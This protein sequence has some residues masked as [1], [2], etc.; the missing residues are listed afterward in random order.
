MLFFI[1]L[2]SLLYFQRDRMVN[3]FGTSDSKGKTGPAGP[4][5]PVGPGGLKEVIQWFPRMILQQIRQELNALTL[6]IENLPPNKDADVELSP[7]KTVN[8]WKL[9]NN[10]DWVLKPVNEGGVLKQVTLELDVLK[11]YGLVFNKSKGIMYHMEQHTMFLTVLSNVL[12]TLTF[13]VGIPDD[14]DDEDDDDVSDKEGEEE[15]IISDYRWTVFHKS[16]EK[17]RGVSIIPKPDEK[18]DLYL[19][20]VQGENRNQRIKFGKDLKRKLYYTLQVYWSETEKT[21]FA[22]LYKDGEP[23]IKE[24]IFPWSEPAD[25][26][27]PAFYLG[28]FNAST[29]GDFRVVESKCFTGIITNV[30]IIRHYSKTP[31]PKEIMSF[32]IER[33]T[34]MNDDWIQAPNA[35]KDYIADSPIVKRKKVT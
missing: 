22:S 28:G 12:L 8:I 11:R 33:Q 13:L 31:I 16:P 9:F 25:M 35:A 10:K 17:F 23:L 4:P 26:T 27:S 34:L 6:L 3:I 15:F 29:T 20:G 18:F 14:E 32:I 19:Y 30:E 2:H 24:T 1:R 21:V 7:Q 5:G